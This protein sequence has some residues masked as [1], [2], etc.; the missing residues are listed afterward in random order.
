MT[1]SQAKK[2]KLSPG[3]GIRCY[4]DLPEVYMLFLLG[5]QRVPIDS[6]HDLQIHCVVRSRSC[7]ARFLSPIRTYV[8]AINTVPGMYFI[9]TGKRGSAII[10]GPSAAWSSTAVIYWLVF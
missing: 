3:C 5:A 10:A 8:P 9:Y 6:T 7:S 1:F 2:L 4:G